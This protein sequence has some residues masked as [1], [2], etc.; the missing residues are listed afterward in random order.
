MRVAFVIWNPFQLLQFESIA[1]KLHKPTFFLIDKENNI[2]L[3]SKKMLNNPAWRFEFVKPSE[4]TLID[5]THD[6]ILFQ[7]P[8]PNI[9]KITKSRLVSIQYGLAKERH[10]YGE[11]RSLADMNLM[12]GKY[13]A[14]IVSHF[15]PSFA[16]G[17][18]KFDNWNLVKS[19]NADKEK[20]YN[21]LGLDVAK[22]TLLYMPTWGE[23][24]SY[25]E[26][27]ESIARLQ[28][29]YN[30][31]L[32]MHHNN[33]AKTPEWI[34][35]AKQYKLKHVFDGSA[36]QLKLLC[37]ADLII[38][39][40]SGAIF[41]GMYAQKPILLYQA[42][43]EN[44]IGLQKFDLQS[45]EFSR[46][47]DIGYV[48]DKLE[49][50]ESCI[51]YCLEHAKDL[52]EKAKALRE[53]LFYQSDEQSAS[54][55]CVMYIRQLFEGNIEPL[56]FPQLYVRETVQALR[57]VRPRVNRLEKQLRNDKLPVYKKIFKSFK[58]VKKI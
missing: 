53:D 37:A 56:S 35:S 47:D 50:F 49:L 23:L 42:G 40:F 57:I 44:K 24:G 11:W 13:S 41:D 38:S 58:I 28:D 15:S 1:N 22:K 45:L 4:I 34:Q 46:R 19:H 55:R 33:D 14:N 43:I 8:F 7:S 3:F 36:D 21:E 12:Y 2:K 27:L 9:E 16:V 29:S 39:D 26:L 20:L 17:N 18:P 6:V 54:E 25:F 10:N 51:E 5:G 48:C 30:I 52:V 32:K 31:I